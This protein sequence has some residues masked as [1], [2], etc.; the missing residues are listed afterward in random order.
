MTMF[1]PGQ[2]V[3]LEC[4]ATYLYAEVIQILSERGLGWIR[5]LMLVQ[6]PYPLSST[7]VDAPEDAESVCLQGAQAAPDLLWP[8]N[9]FRA[10]LDTEVIPL[11]AA[12]HHTP[13]SPAQK[14]RV[15]QT[16]RQ[17]LDRLWAHHNVPS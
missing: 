1:K 12:L 14:T 13:T 17:W 4:E 11:V 7:L 3:C 16:F 6:A 10:A 2:I 15:N 9:Q 8:L 5:P